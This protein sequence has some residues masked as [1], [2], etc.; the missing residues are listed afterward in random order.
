MNYLLNINIM[1]I[2][3]ELAITL[4]CFD[5]IVKFYTEHY[6]FPSNLF[7]FRVIKMIEH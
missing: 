3:L 6:I 1:Q 5:V 4:I 2:I 7:F